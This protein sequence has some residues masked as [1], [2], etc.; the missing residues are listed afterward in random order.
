MTQS[1]VFLVLVDAIAG[2][3]AAYAK[4]F[5][6]VHMA[7]MRRLAGIDRA[8]A[9]RLQALDGMP[10]PAQLCGYYETPNCSELLDTIAANKGTEALPASDLQGKMVWRVLETAAT[11]GE[12]RRGED[13]AKIL[14]CMFNA[15]HDFAG[16]CDDLPIAAARL[17]R[18]GSIQPARGREYES[19]LFLWL[20]EGADPVAHVASIGERLG[21][22]GTRFLLVSADR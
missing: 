15:E 22:D 4:W 13:L 2:E 3:E 11:L 8:F 19:V 16:L 9:G 1:D 6:G 14:I 20:H 7:D 17:T 10:P 5:C 21:A 12:A 18:I